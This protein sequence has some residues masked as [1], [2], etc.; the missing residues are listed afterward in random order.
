MTVSTKIEFTDKCDSVLAGIQKVYRRLNDIGL[1]MSLI[2]VC[3]YLL[4]FLLKVF[5]INFYDNESH[6]TSR[7]A[8][9]LLKSS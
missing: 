2:S 5:A 8:F 1:L 7:R 3:G 6:N 4:M 9:Y